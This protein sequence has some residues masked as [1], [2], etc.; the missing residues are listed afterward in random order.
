MANII[1]TPFASFVKG[2]VIQRQ[3][4]LGASNLGADDLK[5]ITTKTPWLRLASSVNLT[6]KM[7]VKTNEDGSKTEIFDD[8]VLGKLINAGVDKN[9]IVGDNLAKNFILQG[10]S[11]SLNENKNEYSGTESNNAA[12]AESVFRLKKGLNY[13]NDNIFNGAYGWGG[14]SER[15]FVPM[16][17]IESSSTT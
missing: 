12:S 1:G 3:T 4:I 14:T 11:I 9:S 17:G 5:F 2:Q 10:G 15:G 13:G 8:S 7:K 6:G 16:P